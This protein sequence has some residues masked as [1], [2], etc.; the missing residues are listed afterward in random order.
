MPKQ[1][2]SFVVPVEAELTVEAFDS[3]SAQKKVER[4]LRK[5][6][7]LEADVASTDRVWVY[8]ATAAEPV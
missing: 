6:H 1:K 4:A 7:T 5:V 3:A 2:R 8:D